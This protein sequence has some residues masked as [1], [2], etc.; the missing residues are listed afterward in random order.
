MI[1][2]SVEV[3]FLQ[4]CCGTAKTLCLSNCALSLVYSILVRILYWVF[5]S[6]IGLYF[7]GKC[8]AIGSLG[9]RTVL[10]RLSASGICLLKCC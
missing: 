3:P 1:C 4:A 6:A 2:W 8:V 10:A 7:S 5:N 9:N